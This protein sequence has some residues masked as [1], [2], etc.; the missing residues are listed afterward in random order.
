M[1]DLPD[2]RRF[3][4]P[5]SED[6]PG[7]DRLGRADTEQLDIS[8]PS[9]IDVRPD[10]AAADA[11]PSRWAWAEPGSQPPDH[12]ATAATPGGTAEPS[13]W[14][15]PSA[16]DTWSWQHAGD[17]AVPVSA[18]GPADSDG[19][20]EPPAARR[21]PGWGPLVGTV[22]AAALLAGGIGGVGGAYLA[23][24]GVLGVG[25]SNYQAPKP[26]P[27]AQSRPSGSVASIAATALPSV[28]TIKVATDNGSA[29]GSGWAFDDQGH[30][31]TNNHVVEGASNGTVDLVLSNGRHVEATVVGKDSSYDLAALKV[32]GVDLAPL[33]IGS[34]ADLVVGDPVIAVGAPLGLQSTVTTGIVSALNRPV[35]AGNGQSTSFI[36]AIQTD[37]AINPGNSGGPLLNMEG[38]VVG[39][40]SAIARVPGASSTEQGG[41][42]G[43]GFAIPSDQVRRT[44]EQLIRY[45]KAE[46]PV[47]GVRLDTQYDGE[48][49]KIASSG[50]QPVT[51]G[52]PA[53]KAGLKAGDVIIAFDGRPMTDP[54]ELVVAIRSKAVGDEVTLKVR[55]GT[56]EFDARMTLQKAPSS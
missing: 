39:V 22:A 48:G 30:I 12:G 3:A 49:V 2:D 13:A 6:P 38:Q 16:Q 26:G 32:T 18:P 44:V 23:N 15:P 55:R 51:P 29:T 5:P 35:S 24:S 37:A 54:D 17:G 31:V 43:L 52:G 4:P 21:R 28:V 56:R 40:N 19:P 11:G 14:G 36:N 27:A 25:R 41:N 1:T 8:Q 9:Q 10:A 7:P 47:I 34:S 53:D 50:D 33:P 45:G 42:I 46:H 20:H